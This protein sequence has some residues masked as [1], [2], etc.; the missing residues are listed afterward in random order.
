MQRR[1]KIIGAGSIG[2]HLA[3][4]SRRMGW[5]VT[6]VDTNPAALERMR[7]DIYPTRYGK[8]DSEI[9]LVEAKNLPRGKFDII[10]IGT[11]PSS[12]IPL[13][14]EALKEKPLLLQ[15]EKPLCPPYEPKL[16]AFLKAVKKSRTK[17]VIGYDHAIS[18]AAD[19][20]SELLKKKIIGE[21]VTLDVEFREHWQGIFKAHPWLSGPHDSYLGYWK[22]GGGA[23]GEHS[24]AL[25]LWQYFAQA[26]GIGE[27]KQVSS[28]LKIEKNGGT[29]YDSIASFLLETDTGFVGRAIQDV[30]TKPTR[31][32][33]RIQGTL[34]YIEWL[35]GGA[36]GGDLIRYESNGET[37]EE[38]FEKKR[39]DDFYQETL[40]MEA[41]LSGEKKE[42]DS[43]LSLASA[44]SVMRVLEAAWKGKNKFQKISR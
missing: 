11:P 16:D 40:H 23:S 15:I 27:W 1:V 38:I 14:I 5:S 31:K 24:H 32:H 37:K 41:V 21:P 8:W 39:P 17:V 2:N 19:R 42:K 29:E 44:V 22:K 25:H 20:I 12:H 33:V 34:G 35:L 26:M 4:A 6:V 36:P 10:M 9:E 18:K 7:T 3:Q 13:A 30:V 43:P 28:V